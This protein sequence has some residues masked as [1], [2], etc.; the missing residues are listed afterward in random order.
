[1]HWMMRQLHVDGNYEEGLCMFW[2]LLYIAASAWVSVEPLTPNH[3]IVQI[4]ADLSPYTDNMYGMGSTAMLE[5][6]VLP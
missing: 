6:I 3:E 4:Y 5:A 2:N 1:M